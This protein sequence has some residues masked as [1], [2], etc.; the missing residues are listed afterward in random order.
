MSSL[1]VS[2][3]KQTPRRFSVSSL[4]IDLEAPTTAHSKN[5]SSAFLQEVEEYLKRY[6]NTQ[7]IDVCL[8]DLNGHIRGKR[9]D[10]NS[11]RQL[12]KGCYFPLSVYAMNLDGKVNE[13]TGL[14]KYIGEPDRL[15][16]P[17]LG[18]LKPAAIQPELNAQ[19]YVSM[20]DDTLIDCPYEPRN[21]L[22]KIVNQLHAEQYYPVMSAE[23]EFYLFDITAS[24]RDA[25]LSNQSF[26]MDMPERDLQV[27]QE[28]ERIAK[29]QSI[30]ITGLV[31]ESAMSQYEINILHRPDILTLCDQIMSLK[32]IVKQVAKQFHMQACFL[33]KPD[34]H[35]AGSGMHFHLSICDSNLQNRFRTS[36]PDQPC[37]A[38]QQAISGLV[39]LMP[40]SM[41]ILAPNINSYRRFQPGQHVPMEANWNINNRNVAIRIPCADAENQR[42]EYRVAGADC[43]PYLTVAVILTGILHG[44]EHS[45]EMPKPSHQIK[46][47]HEHIFLP[48]QQ[49]DA[50]DRFKNNTTLQHYL[51]REFCEL[52]HTLKYAEHQHVYQQITIAEKAWDL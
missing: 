10:I 34:L 5:N 13:E 37:N 2:M 17:I 14:G 46:Q 32:R 20:Q 15:C 27:L 6:P 38:L 7:H 33:A 24:S 30:P 18:S 8:H 49:L 52:W 48:Q 39:D 19:V 1:I 31:A 22:K 4:P 43:N 42:L 11:L 50:L 23:L 41:A 9:I 51:G 21:V 12:D 36:S 29:L 25:L 47:L 44:I 16:R 26:D 45:L 28:I 35:Q 3:S 40:A